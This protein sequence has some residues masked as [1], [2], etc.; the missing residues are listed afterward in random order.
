MSGLHP[1]GL[2]PT[3]SAI[4]PL[5]EPGPCGYATEAPP[6]GHAGLS[7]PR[8]PCSGPA[9]PVAEPADGFGRTLR[10]MRIG[11]VGH[12]GRHVH[13]VPGR[14]GVQHPAA[15]GW[16][17][18]ARMIH[19]FDA[20]IQSPRPSRPSRSGADQHGGSGPSAEHC[21]DVRSPAY[22]GWPSGL[23]DLCVS[24]SWGAVPQVEQG[25][26]DSGPDPW[27]AHVV[28]AAAAD[29][30]PPAGL[31]RGGG[32]RGSPQRGDPPRG[33]SRSSGPEPGFW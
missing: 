24:A 10:E 3:C 28:I 7:E 31:V 14:S 32:R 20:W 9:V 23:R 5:R 6:R 33:T 19:L 16:W 11:R 27:T 13:A 26:S 12:R 15:W 25:S 22:P 21:Y 30:D 4:T 17:M 1:R 8:L 29:P 2:A 18:R